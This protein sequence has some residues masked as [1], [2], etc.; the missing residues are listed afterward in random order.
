MEIARKVEI[1]LGPPPRTV[2]WLECGLDDVLSRR[3]CSSLVKGG[4]GK[5]RDVSV[6]HAL[7]TGKHFSPLRSSVGKVCGESEKSGE[8]GET[9]EV[10]GSSLS[11]LGVGDVA[12]ET[13]IALQLI[14]GRERD[15]KAPL[16]FR[17]KVPSKRG[18]LGSLE[19]W[20]AM[21]TRGVKILNECSNECGGVKWV[22]VVNRGPGA[23]FN[24][25]S[26][27]GE[28]GP[29]RAAAVTVPIYNRGNRHPMVEA[30]GRK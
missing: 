16:I 13:L 9:G 30:L 7:S 21:S 8:T 5:E 24:P 18:N 19:W 25:R 20:S 12:R 29:K 10:G 3:L 27:G 11:G 6:Y 28:E 23:T 2:S 14:G 17:H 15:V 22:R 1:C 26:G 4:V